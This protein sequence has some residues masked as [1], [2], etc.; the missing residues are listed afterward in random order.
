MTDFAELHR[1]LHDTLE[2]ELPYL[3]DVDDE[4]VWDFVGILCDVAKAMGTVAVF[5]TLHD[6]TETT[7][8]GQTHIVFGAVP[9]GESGEHVAVVDMRLTE[10]QKKG[11]AQH[12]H[13]N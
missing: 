6:P 9:L 12:P 1:A 5:I 7:K 4:H 10:T 3:T 13:L 11:G 8:E 2:T